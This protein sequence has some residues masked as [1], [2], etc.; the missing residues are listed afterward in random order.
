MG[1]LAVLRRVCGPLW[2][3]VNALGQLQQLARDRKP[4]VQFSERLANL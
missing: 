4:S 2:L 1:D 3:I